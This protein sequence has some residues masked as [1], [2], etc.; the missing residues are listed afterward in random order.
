MHEVEYQLRQILPVP[1]AD[2]SESDS[3]S[4]LKSPQTMVSL[5]LQCHIINLKMERLRF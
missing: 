2:L 3:H 1:E 5:G 4:T